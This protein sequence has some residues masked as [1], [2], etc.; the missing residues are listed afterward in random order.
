MRFEEQRVSGCYV[1]SLDLAEDER[2]FFARAFSTQEFA[3]AGLVAKIAQI[4]LARSEQAGTTR[5]IHWQAEPHQEAKLVRCISGSVFE[6]CVDVRPGSD[7]WGLW[8]GVELTADNR[9]AFYVPPGCGN[10]YQALEDGSEVLYSTSAHYAPGAERGA[11]WDDPAFSIDWPIKRGIVLS[12]K[13]L[14]W[15]DIDKR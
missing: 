3:T 14:S 7:T 10:A 15:P 6:V 11:R 8:T 1:V 2:G 13:D 5:G 12:T 9:L 4:T